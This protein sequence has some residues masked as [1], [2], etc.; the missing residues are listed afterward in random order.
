MTS[1]SDSALLSNN[2]I[3][4]F[5]DDAK[6]E[7]MIMTDHDRMSLRED[8]RKKSEWSQ[9]WEMH[10]NVN[11]CHILQVGI[12]NQKFDYDMNDT[13]LEKR[14]NAS[15]NLELRLR[16]ASNSPS[17]AKVPQVKLIECW[18]LR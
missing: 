2:L 8:L 12:R 5:A 10:F 14:T 4:E 13:K 7:N 18:V 3:S 9:R 6:I 15:K 1:K 11:R 16:R 17:N